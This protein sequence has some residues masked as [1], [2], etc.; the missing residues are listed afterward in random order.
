M[1]TAKSEGGDEKELFTIIGTY[2]IDAPAWS[3]DG[4]VIVGISPD[5]SSLRGMDVSSQKQETIISSNEM[6][7]AHAIW[8][9]DGQGLVVLYKGKTA[10]IE[11]I[12]FVSYPDGR[13]RQITHDTNNYAG[14]SVSRDGKTL[15]VVQQA[16][17][18]GFMSCHLDGVGTKRM[19]LPSLPGGQRMSSCGPMKKI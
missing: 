16:E 4:K 2:G 8:L 11:Q 7:F 18:L 1:I 17:A 14:M 9:P 15:A 13:F 19:K 10:K 3:P 5:G 12:G 6:L